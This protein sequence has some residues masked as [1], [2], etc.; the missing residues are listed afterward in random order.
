MAQSRQSCE[1][2]KSFERYQGGNSVIL[3]ELTKISDRRERRQPT[4]RQLEGWNE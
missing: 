4:Q 1:F 2:I 3:R